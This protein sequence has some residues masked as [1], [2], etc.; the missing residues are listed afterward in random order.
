MDDKIKAL[1][2]RDLESGKY[3]QGESCLRP[4]KRKFCCIGVLCDT[5]R[6]ETGEGRWVWSESDGGYLY[7]QKGAGM[8]GGEGS[9]L[10]LFVARWAGLTRHR[11]FSSWNGDIKIKGMDTLIG[12]NDDGDSF[13]DISEVI[14][15]NL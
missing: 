10:P 7:V 9:T 4:N 12:M 11:G 14:K 15:K 8:E 2:N 1:W 6:K 5:H 3:K 13:M